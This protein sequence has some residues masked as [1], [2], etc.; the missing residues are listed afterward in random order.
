[1]VV[2]IVA[3]GE[4]DGQSSLREEVERLRLAWL[5]TRPME[6]MAFLVAVQPFHNP[7]EHV[8]VVAERHGRAVQFLS[9]VPVYERN[10]WL[11][12]DVLRGPDAPN[13]TSEMM[14]DCL[15]RELVGDGPDGARAAGVWIT[16]GLTPLAGD[17]PWW[18]RAARDVTAPL[19]DFDGLRRF[20]SRLAPSHWD[21]VWLVWD[22]GP[23]PL[24]LVD[25]LRAFAGGGLWLFAW[26][27]LIRH[28]NG[29]PWAVAVPL[30][31][32][33]MLLGALAL[34]GQAG[35]LGF[36]SGVLAAWVVFDSV[37]A[38]LLFGTARRPSPQWLLPL[39][40]AA[41]F[42]AAFSLRHLLVFGLG[43]TWP[44]ALLRA[45]AAL[46]PVLGTAGLS[47]ALWLMRRGR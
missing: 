26:R 36:S 12:E 7:P 19:Y 41:A 10:G 39:T 6:P 47:R 15:M 43:H 37:L 22:R 24:V 32:W 14:L 16:P 9:A 45:L 46:G 29:P 44:S 30:V 33:T 3:P 11:V 31:P 38:W 35:V 25:V 18:L 17:L 28:P 4:L 42:D 5:A 20:R 23:A 8:Y 27:S 21:P 1:M 34:A 13:G 2:R 40:L